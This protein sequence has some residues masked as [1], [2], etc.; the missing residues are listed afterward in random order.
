MQR[1][2]KQILSEKKPKDT[3]QHPSFRVIPRLL[4]RSV[5]FQHEAVYLLWLHQPPLL[6]AARTSTE[7]SED[8]VPPQVPNHPSD[9]GATAS[10]TS[11]SRS[12]ATQAREVAFHR[13]L[14]ARQE[15]LATQEEL[16]LLLELL[17]RM[18]K[19][20][21][22]SASGYAGR[23]FIPETLGGRPLQEAAEQCGE[24]VLNYDVFCQVRDAAPLAI[25]RLMTASAFS[26]LPRDAEDCVS[27]AGVFAFLQARSAADGVRVALSAY[28]TDG[29]DALTE[30]QLEN[31]VFDIIPVFPALAAVPEEFV[32]FYVF[33][34]V[35]KLMFVTGT[36]GRRIAIA[37]LAM[38]PAMAA[39]QQQ[40]FAPVPGAPRGAPPLPAIG[41][42]TPPGSPAPAGPLASHWF[43]PASAIYVYNLYMTLDSD[44]SG[45]LTARELCGYGSGSWNRVFVDA[46][47]DEV[48]SFKQGAV[49]YKGYLDFVL[50]AEGRNTLPGMR[51]AFQA[52]DR[53]HKGFMSL[54]DVAWAF[55]GINEAM[56]RS[57]EEAVPIKYI[58]TE[59]TDMVGPQD[60]SRVSMQDLLACK[61]GPTFLHCLTDV[62]GFWLYSNRE[63]LMHA[64]VEGE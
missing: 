7:D 48:A 50:A 23:I 39:L 22:A 58:V 6:Q 2:C 12:L 13:A 34:A 5:C 14:L 52:L 64:D 57:G 18:A 40:A 47:L 42:H 53:G 56:Q 44:G 3:Q 8:L 36:K 60:P 59:L 49:D 63:M 16:Q 51:Y 26:A 29:R 9:P 1:L 28:D 10:S 17:Q 35:R 38:S 21:K 24:G 32:P 41:L 37:D 54:Q 61:M 4:P 15:Q 55:K 19:P 46:L 62:R 45:M 33:H 20:A 27:A 30:E 11:S 31:Y 43:A 25:A